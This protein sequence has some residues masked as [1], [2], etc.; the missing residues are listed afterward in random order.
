MSTFN[1]RSWT[2][3]A[4]TLT[5]MRPCGS[6]RVAMLKSKSMGCQ[7]QMFDAFR[8]KKMFSGLISQCIHPAAWKAYGTSYFADHSCPMQP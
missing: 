4:W 1:D 8:R 6:G 5:F 2:R 7:V 3:E